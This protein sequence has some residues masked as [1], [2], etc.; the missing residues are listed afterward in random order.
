MCEACPAGQYQSQDNFIGG[1]CSPCPEGSDCASDPCL[2]TSAP[3]T[4]PT[5]SPTHPCLGGDHGCDP[6]ST[7]CE[8]TGL[9]GGPFC[10]C[11]PGFTGGTPTSKSCVADVAD[12]TVPTAAPTSTEVPTAMPTS[13]PT[14]FPS[15]APTAAPTLE[16]SLLCE[17]IKCWGEDTQDVTFLPGQHPDC[18]MCDEIK[19]TCCNRFVA[20]SPGAC[21][22]CVLTEGATFPS[23]STCAPTPSPTPALP[24]PVTPTGEPTKGPTAPTGAPSAMPSYDPAKLFSCWAETNPL[25]EYTDPDTGQSFSSPSCNMC[26]SAFTTCCNNYVAEVARY[27]RNGNQY[28]RPVLEP[29][30][31]P[32]G[33]AV[34]EDMCNRCVADIADADESCEYE[35]YTDA[36][37]AVPTVPPTAL[38]C[39]E[40]NGGCDLATTTCRQTN[41]AQEHECECLP[42]FN[43]FSDTRCIATAVPTPTPSAAPTKMFGCQC[44]TFNTCANWL[45]CDA[46]THHCWVAYDGEARA[47]CL[48]ESG[49][50]DEYIC[51]CPRGYDEI[52]PHVGHGAT[53][54]HMCGRSSVRYKYSPIQLP[55]IQLVP[56]P[57]LVC[58]PSGQTI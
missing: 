13:I 43:P 2:G 14:Q 55:H 28:W 19:P 57:C 30:Q 8:Q 39:D 22:N 41:T 45:H 31:G 34:L 1:S 46:G 18:N 4:P 10:A 24:T 37:T 38:S 47:T 17:E 50:P 11:L 5:A 40:N 36:P 33:G 21:Q 12:T 42:G 6:A 23:C 35:V 3:T 51:V 56:S 25:R 32:G 16:P 49:D 15:S 7:I 44:G 27:W 29:Y 52:V 58:P 9:E 54:Q 20:M 48:E 26:P 53:Q